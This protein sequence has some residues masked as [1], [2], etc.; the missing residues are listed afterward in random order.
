[1]LRHKCL[2]RGHPSLPIETCS[3]K[4]ISIDY[5]KQAVKT[6]TGQPE[7]RQELLHGPEAVAVCTWDNGSTYQSHLPKLLLEYRAF[8]RVK[9]KATEETKATGKANAKGKAEAKG[10]AAAPPTEEELSDELSEEDS[11]E[12][13]AEPPGAAEDDP[14]VVEPPAANE[15]IPPDTRQGP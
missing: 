6:N 8:A 15:D 10:K 12:E 4:V 13:I 3:Y 7:E 11:E 2:R 9:T 14:A 5:S 1:M